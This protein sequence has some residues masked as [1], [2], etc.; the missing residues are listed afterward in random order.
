MRKIRLNQLRGKNKNKFYALVDD[1]DYE[2]LNQWKWSA[3]KMG[4]TYY[5]VRN[6]YFPKT[7]KRKNILMHRVILNVPGNM[8]TDHRD[9]NGLHNQK[10]NLRA[11]TTKENCRNSHKQYRKTYS[12]YKGVTWNKVN[13]KWMVQI[14][15]TKNGEKIKYNLGN[16][17]SER[18]AAK[19]Y[20]AKAKELFGEYAKLNF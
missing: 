13:K 7:R 2:F 16:F 12:R 9:G 14:R 11:C 15:I 1:E 19:V 4:H 10:K 8:D 6:L 20:D 17:N 5:A 18:K 3:H